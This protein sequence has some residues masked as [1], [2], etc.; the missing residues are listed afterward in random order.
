MGTIKNELKESER[1]YFNLINN[2][3]DVVV[4]LSLDFT[5]TYINSQVY[6]VFGYSPEELIGKRNINMIHPDDISKI[7]EAIKNTIKTGETI[8]EEFR[9]QHK[10]GHYIPVAARGRKV[11]YNNQTKIVAV[12]RDIMEEK[13]T[14]QRFKESEK[15]YRLITE[16][17]QDIVYTLNMNLNNTYISPSVYNVLGYDV[18]EAILMSPKDSV[19]KDDWEKIARIYKEES[20]LERNKSIKKDLN[21]KR[22]FVVKEKHKDGRLLKMEHT[23]SWLRDETGGAKGILGV[24][25]DVT[26]RKKT[27][28]LLKESERKFRTIFNS[29]PDL[30]FLVDDDSTILEYSG[31]KE[32]LYVPPEAF[33][34]K[35]MT[36]VLPSDVTKL[37]KT[38]INNTLKYEKPQI[39]EYSLPIEN[40]I[41]YFEA[42]FLPFTDKQIA[43]FIRNI[44]EKK[45]AEQKLKIS[46]AKYRDAYNRAE[47]FKD[48]FYHDINNICS[49]IKFSI[50]LSE[51]YLNESGKEREIKD[52][53]NLIREQFIKSQKLISNLQNLSNLESSNLSLKI[54]N[55]SKTLDEAIQ[56]IENSLPTKNININLEPFEKEIFVNADELL[57]DI[58]D[59]ILFNAVNHNDNSQIEIT[60]KNSRERKLNKSYIKFEFKDNGI[61]I[62]DERKG[63]LFQEKFCNKKGSKGLGV[64]LTLVKKIID[65][66]NGQIW[67]E[68]RVKK[69]YS[70]GSIF[71][72]LIPEAVK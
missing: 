1:N 15:K 59:N 27:E 68:D 24:A 7:Q 38:A 13:E 55:A 35:K 65:N 8:T 50:D 49:N 48:L 3:L 41:K 19:H 18:D 34:G 11:E 61:G 72:I 44:T 57:M 47:L 33:L 21:R 6:D 58:F 22:V 51:T 12:F 45:E 5:T 20:K 67:V 70:K 36:K 26:E 4:E 14:E 10:N 52:L 16:N 31:K 40:N 23:I 46:E 39:I 53:Y 42:R 2:I 17:S 28:E 64:G 56:F 43:L 25:R 69:D 60:I 63:N 9:I 62:T 37:I 30:F 54:I 32:D 66:Y 29:I 71:T